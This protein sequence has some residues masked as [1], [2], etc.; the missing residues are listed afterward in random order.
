MIRAF[1][2]AIEP[3]PLLIFEQFCWA[4]FSATSRRRTL[5]VGQFQRIIF[6][7]LTAPVRVRYE[8]SSWVRMAPYRVLGMQA[9]AYRWRGKRGCSEKAGCSGLDGSIGVSTLSIVERFP[10]QFRVVALA[11]GKNLSKLKEQVVLF[12]PEIVSLTSEADAKDLRAQLPNFR[13]EIYGA[14]GA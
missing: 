5:G 7:N 8:C 4:I 6:A 10:E 9:I 11:A 14:T 1:L 2:I 3:M 12:Q 13:G